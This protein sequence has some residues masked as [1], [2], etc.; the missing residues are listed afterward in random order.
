MW[1]AR[2]NREKPRFSGW[3][4]WQFTDKAVLYGVSGYVD[5]SVKP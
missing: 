1:I 2:Y 5:L 4:L 3:T